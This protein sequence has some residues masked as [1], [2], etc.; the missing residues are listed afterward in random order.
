MGGSRAA[1]ETRAVEL[2]GV[3]VEA[4]GVLE[5]E[6]VVDLARG[7]EVAH[8]RMSRSKVCPRSE[9]RFIGGGTASDGEPAFT[10]DGVAE[11]R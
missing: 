7:V 6:V 11:R 9:V 5:P 10:G 2:D 1:H 4:E 8:D 3:V